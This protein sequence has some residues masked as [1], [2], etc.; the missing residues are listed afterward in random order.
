[1]R[2][3][4]LVFFSVLLQSGQLFGQ[5]GESGEIG[6]PP[7]PQKRVHYVN[8][9]NANNGYG[10]SWGTAFNNL[11]DALD[12]AFSDDEIWV[13]AGTYWP[14]KAVTNKS[15]NEF[16]VSFVLKTDKVK[17][18][19]GFPATGNPTMD[20]RNRAVHK[21]ILSGDIGKDDH[22]D[23]TINGVNAAHVVI[24]ISNDVLL[25]GFIISGG[26]AIEYSSLFIDDYEIKND[27]G[28]GILNAAHSKLI[29]KN[30]IVKANRAYYGAGIANDTGADPEFVNVLICGNFSYTHG[31]GMYNNGADP[32]LRNVTISGNSDGMYS[33]YS[34]TKPS[35][36]Q[37]FNTIIMGNYFANDVYAIG[38]P[39]YYHHCLIGD[40]YYNG[41]ALASEILASD[42]FMYW[43][44]P[45]PTGL[46]I[47]DNYRLK[48]GCFAINRGNNNYIEDEP[49]DLYGKPRIMN[50][51]VDLGAS[52]F[53]YITM[54]DVTLKEMSYDVDDLKINLYKSDGT[55]VWE[56]ESGE[57]RVSVV[58]PGYIMSYYNEDEKQ[59]STWKDATPIH[60]DRAN[61]ADQKIPITVTLIPELPI[62]TGTITISGALGLADNDESNTKIRPV[63]NLN[64]NVSL[65]KSTALKSPDGYVLVKTVQTTDGR[66][67]FTNLPEG[68]YRIVA[69][70]PGYESG[71]V[72]VHV[73]EGMKTVNFIVKTDTKT[74]ISESETLTEAP[75]WQAKNIKVYPNPATDVLHVSG[76]EGN[77]TVK[78]MNILGQ[79]VYSTAGSSPE[80][81]LNIGHLPSGMYFLR[82]ESNQKATTCK[83]IKQ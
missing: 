69:D 64:G 83:I 55:Q 31:S 43:V 13:A 1:M 79:S 53:Y 23:G 58:Y 12:A 60:I 67:T 49:T 15:N 24:N 51:A 62:E 80:L 65:Y 42:I 17:I 32:V 2:H 63:A 68:N 10:T 26:D 81:L 78:I 19:G 54:L 66:Y 47:Y 82:V 46:S 72:D 18:Y 5:P 73:V 25:D 41:P 9:I 38:T 29:L 3:F 4:L 34:D 45:T 22:S 50:D 30:S 75:S 33:A 37:L 59:A 14:T 28:G 39:D 44:A 48:A 7:Y 77:Y 35:N 16:D 76:L 74:I 21:T 57:Y 20:D 8:A 61:G 40:L 36:P 27:Y 70:I 6:E 71:A 52:E 11:Q 56:L